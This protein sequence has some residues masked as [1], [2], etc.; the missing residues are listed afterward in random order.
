MAGH[1]PI[2]GEQMD[3]PWISRRD[4][5]SIGDHWMRDTAGRLWVYVEQAMSRP[6]QAQTGSIIKPGGVWVRQETALVIATGFSEKHLHGAGAES[7]DPE[8]AAAAFQSYGHGPAVNLARNIEELQ[9][10]ADGA[11]GRIHTGRDGANIHDEPMHYR[12]RA[13]F[14]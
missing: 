3:C 13:R 11:A 14:P 1:L 6:I 2:D 10:Q 8:E 7:C 12:T 9:N 5:G 4:T